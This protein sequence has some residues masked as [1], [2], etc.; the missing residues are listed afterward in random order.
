M[1]VAVARAQALKVLGQASAGEDQG[2]DVKREKRVTLRVYVRGQYIEYA[3]DNLLRHRAVLQE[4]ESDFGNFF[5]KPMTDINEMDV[6]RCRAR[7]VKEEKPVAFATVQRSFTALKG[8]LNTAHETHKVITHQQLSAVTLKRTTAQLETSDEK[9]PR[10]L[11]RTEP[12][13]TPGWLPHLMPA[14]RECVPVVCR[15]WPASIPT[16]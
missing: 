5:D 9:P 13:N 14:R 1:T 3:Q 8:C 16:I 7:R 10:C 2:R 11:T 15:A 12:M 4:L 6:Q